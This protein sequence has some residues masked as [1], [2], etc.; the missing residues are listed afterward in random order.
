[1]CTQGHIDGYHSEQRVFFD[2]AT[3]LVLV[4]RPNKIEAY[5]LPKEDGFDPALNRKCW[6]VGVENLDQF[7][8][9][10]ISL[11]AKT[12][13]IHRSNKLIQFVD[14]ATGNLFLQGCKNPKRDI[15]GL[16]FVESAAY[17]LIMVT[18][19][20]IEFYNFTSLKREGLKMMER[21]RHVIKWYLYTFATRVLLLG[22]GQ[23]G[24]RVTGYQFTVT[25]MIKLPF[26][27]LEPAIVPSVDPETFMEVTPKAKRPSAI[28]SSNDIVL[29]RLYNRVFFCHIDRKKKRL[30]FYLVFMDIL[31]MAR[32]Y[33]MVNDA[34]H[35]N[36]VDNVL[37]V[38]HTNSS[39]VAVYDL[40]SPSSLPIGSPL[41]VSGEMFRSGN[42]VGPSGEGTDTPTSSPATPMKL[43][44]IK[45]FN[46]DWRFFQPDLV[47]DDNGNI[48]RFQLDLEGVVTSFSDPAPLIGFL[49]RRRVAWVPSAHPRA[50]L[51]SSLRSNIRQKYGVRTMRDVFSMLHYDGSENVYPSSSERIAPA[52][53][54]L[55]TPMLKSKDVIADVFKYLYNEDAV[56]TSH[57]ETCLV[58]F[59]KSADGKKIQLD[60]SAYVV[61]TDL[62]IKQKKFFQL[63]QLLGGLKDA[64]A[65]IVA[66][67]LE[68][69]ASHG[70]YVEL[71]LD[72]FAHV[73]VRES[74]WK[75]SNAM[76]L[77]CASLLKHG[78][79]IKGEVS[80]SDPT[81]HV[82]CSYES[83][84]APSRHVSSG[85]SVP[86][87]SAGNKQRSS[88]R[89]RQEIP[90]RTKHP[91]S[92]TPC[93]PNVAHLAN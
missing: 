42:R 37:L 34:L 54:K 2:D 57:L 75:D 61:W 31:M 18:D 20:A 52:A 36:V 27:D 45:S 64:Q 14:R 65:V 7:I 44:N 16:F 50:L 58:E 68:G 60:A 91:L 85:Q 88:H 12:L 55:Q 89:C 87:G 83:S 79:V 69:L 22:T 82:L 76:E 71:G 56:E 6:E 17:D 38:H 15:L 48:Y 67:H 21:M 62:L 46:S 66:Q 53:L 30:R 47:I 13:A 5:D 11:D 28:V 26:V 86:G 25:Q 41:P 74:N 23:N 49:N 35:F 72:T 84:P 43:Q 92:T 93:I 63:Q 24:S 90:H 80:D 8:S 10:Q 19:T 9:V 29:L 33:D 4:P 70:M 39:V 32:E 40:A 3:R 73:A 77:Y 1:M 59:M 51:V 81:S 78:K